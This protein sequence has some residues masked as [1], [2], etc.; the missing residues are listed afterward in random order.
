MTNGNFQVLKTLGINGELRMTL[1]TLT[2]SSRNYGWDCGHFIS[3]CMP[4]SAEGYI[5]N[6]EK[7]Y[8]WMDRSLH[9][10]WAICGLNHGVIYTRQRFHSQIKIAWTLP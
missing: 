10:Y 4:T 3:S 9:I 1:K 8:L 5:F 7:L 2:L 6:T